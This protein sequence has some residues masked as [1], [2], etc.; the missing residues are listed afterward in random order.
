MV[1]PYI[2]YINEHFLHIY[3]LDGEY[4]FEEKE[5]LKVFN[6][7][8]ENIINLRE[9]LIENRHFKNLK[10]ANLDNSNFDNLVLLNNSGIIR[11]AVFLQKN[12]IVE[13]LEKIERSEILKDLNRENN[14]K[15]RLD[16]VWLGIETILKK[17]LN[18]ISEN[19]S[20]TDLEKLILIIG[21]FGREK[22]MS[23]YKKESN[24]K[25]V[26]IDIFEEAFKTVL[27]STK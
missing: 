10:I 17:Q 11:I 23:S 22:N 6:L 12:E 18:N 14:E 27:N 25:Q 16:E 8:V 3:F 20:L 24:F 21:K 15:N 7:K 4:Y 19:G 1:N 9:K 13:L 5:I 26:A 2:L